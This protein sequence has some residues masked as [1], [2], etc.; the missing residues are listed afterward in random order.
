MRK[1]KLLLYTQ[2]FFF[3]GDI[4]I[5]LVL[6][7]KWL[8]EVTMGYPFVT[9]TI[10]EVHVDFHRETKKRASLLHDKTIISLPIFKA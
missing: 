7:G 5:A 8:V 2:I 4:N 1:K 10:E 3:C 9:P 6:A